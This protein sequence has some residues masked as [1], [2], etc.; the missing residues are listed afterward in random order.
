MNVEMLNISIKSHYLTIL[1][2]TRQKESAL[3]SLGYMVNHP[4]AKFETLLVAL[5]HKVMVLLQQKK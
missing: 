2:I 4:D 3:A 1:F 5:Q